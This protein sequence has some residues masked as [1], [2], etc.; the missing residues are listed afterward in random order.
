L[1][2]LHRRSEFAGVPYETQRQWIRAGRE[3]LLGHGLTPRI[4]VA[5]RHG[6][7]RN[8]LRALREEGMTLLSD[9]LARVPFVRGGVT[10]I[11]QQL[12]EPEEKPSGVWTICLHS[13]TASDELALRVA[14]F[15]RRHA[16]QFSSVDRVLAESPAGRLSP[17]ERIAEI[18]ASLRKRGR[19]KAKQLL[20]GT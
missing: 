16:A 11:P 1:L 17:A 7:D 8:T 4:W 19:R 3:I 15:V 6:F 14:D 2:P 5:P 13:N 12:W 20:I 10:W 9:G 18:L